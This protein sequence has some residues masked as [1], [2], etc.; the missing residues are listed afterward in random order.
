MRAVGAAHETKFRPSL[1]LWMSMRAEVFFVKLMLA[2]YPSA[3]AV[4]R[5]CT[6][7]ANDAKPAVRL[8]L[9]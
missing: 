2:V 4:V 7:L 9:Y 6:R 8:G 5:A 3:N 1:T